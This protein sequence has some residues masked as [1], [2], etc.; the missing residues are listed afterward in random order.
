MSV[1]WEQTVSVKA[2]CG[3]PSRNPN[4]GRESPSRRPRDNARG[5]RRSAGAD[6]QGMLADSCDSKMDHGLTII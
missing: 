6:D 1:E 5:G 3:V 2:P 4:S